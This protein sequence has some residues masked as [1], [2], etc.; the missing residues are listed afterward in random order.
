MDSGVGW[1][2]EQESIGSGRPLSRSFSAGPDARPGPARMTRY[3]F[4]G[5][6]ASWEKCCPFRNVI[7]FPLP[8]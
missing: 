3:D 7:A 6:N 4:F 8:Q 2:D 5:G 1:N